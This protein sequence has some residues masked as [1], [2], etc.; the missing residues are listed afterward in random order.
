VFLCTISSSHCSFFCRFHAILI[1][2]ETLN[3]SPCSDNR[4]ILLFQPEIKNVKFPL[5]AFSHS[6]KDPPDRTFLTSI[7]E[8]GFVIVA[9]CGCVNKESK[10]EI[11]TLLHLQLQSLT[12][13]VEFLLTNHQ[14]YSVDLSKPLGLFGHDLGAS[15]SLLTSKLF[16]S[17]ESFQSIKLN[18][19]VALMPR[20]LN[21]GEIRS[22]VPSFFLAGAGDVLSPTKEILKLYQ[23][24]RATKMVAIAKNVQHS[25]FGKFS[26]LII[27]FFKCFL[28]EDQP[29]CGELLGLRGNQLC[30]TNELEFDFCGVEISEDFSTSGEVRC[31]DK[32]ENEHLACWLAAQAALEMFGRC[33]LLLAQRCC[34]SCKANPAQLAKAE[35]MCIDQSSQCRQLSS[36]EMET[37]FQCTKETASTCCQSCNE[38]LVGNASILKETVDGYPFLEAEAT[39]QDHPIHGT[40]CPVAIAKIL[41]VRQTCPLILKVICC[42]SCNS[43]PVIAAA[44]D[45]Q[46]VCPWLYPAIRDAIGCVD[47]TTCHATAD[48][49]CC[50]SHGGRAKC[51]SNYPI[52]CAN[53]GT[54]ECSGDRCCG[55]E[56]TDCSEH[57]GPRP[58]PDGNI[59]APVGP[60]HPPN[61]PFAPNS[62]VGPVHPAN[63]PFA[64]DS[65]MDPG[66]IQIV[67]DNPN[68]KIYCMNE[69]SSNDSRGFSCTDRY[70]EHPEECHRF[71]VRQHRFT[72]G[73][74]CCACRKDKLDAHR[75]DFEFQDTTAGW[76]RDWEV[77]LGFGFGGGLFFASLCLL[78]VSCFRSHQKPS[79]NTLD[80]ILL[81][82][83][84]G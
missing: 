65:P 38:I 12:Q 66:N 18:A 39:C 36:K 20:Q 30:Q 64:P 29:S 27:S 16:Q 76:Y 8:K 22:T 1:S 47:G 4:S 2:E 35:D 32:N 10:S 53:H 45:L 46:S 67:P 75:P 13:A 26:P 15:A 11:Q 52:M 72:S 42:Q 7:S 3:D 44:N 19:V 77:V 60:V 79:Q 78:V 68:M 71:D 50:A 41:S 69:D 73:S 37:F 9:H 14:K 82:V 59:P 34:E 40:S 81:D 80:K 21:L 74:Q 17:S 28:A 54:Q 31:E 61:V 51:P 84:E 57:G 58:C 62:P 49:N 48:W 83:K 56:T 70:D 6:E 33:P 43:I 24:G 25:E 63:I 23:N 55:I 5:L